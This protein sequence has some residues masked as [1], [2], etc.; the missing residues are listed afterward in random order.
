MAKL[1]TKYLLSMLLI[2]FLGGFVATPGEC[3]IFD[4][5][6]WWKVKKENNQVTIDKG[7]NLKRSQENE[8]IRNSKDL[9]LMKDRLLDNTKANSEHLKDTQKDLADTANKN[10][11]AQQDNTQEKAE[12]LKEQTNNLKV[13]QAGDLKDLDQKNFIK[14]QKSRVKDIRQQQKDMMRNLKKK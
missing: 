12:K 1:I 3:R 11:E 9:E 8:I 13:N 10:M 2:L 4:F 7:F 5:N 14:E 6:W